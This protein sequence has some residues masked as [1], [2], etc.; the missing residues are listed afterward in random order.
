MFEYIFFL[1]IVFLLLCYVRK[2]KNSIF[3][4]LLLII[5]ICF[6]GF[7][8]GIG[9]DY[10]LYEEIYNHTDTIGADFF[11]T[12][13][14]YYS[15]SLFL[16]NIIPDGFWLLI[17][18]FSAITYV[19]I[20]FFCK[21]NSNIPGLSIFL[22]ICLG[23][24]PTSFNI[25]R[26]MASLAI[27]L[28][29]YTYLN[30]KKYFKTCIFFTI[31]ISLHEMSIIPILAILW[32]KVFRKNFNYKMLL[33]LGIL[34]L[35]Q[36]DFIYDILVENILSINVYSNSEKYIPGIGTYLQVVVYLFMYF[37]FNLNKEK[38]IKKDKLNEE[39][40]FLYNL[41]VIITLIGIKNILFIRLSNYLTI[42]SI[43]II[44][45]LYDLYD[46]KNRKLERAALY[47][48]Y[49]IYFFTYIY[50]FNEV[51]PYQSILFK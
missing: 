28:L 24:Y 8:Y 15:F 27:L 22:F 34:V 9:T 2:N 36:Y 46:L 17:F 5:L 12:G 21:E 4:I 42:Y 30:K 25:F 43:I 31:A 45:K 35:F 13:F 37:I 50:S 29:G 38:L 26:Q 11:R 44:P 14:G 10:K 6:S 19:S 48:C 16:H 41:G 3:D 20:Y 18:T 33:F 23:F 32:I 1:G 40:L 7:R 51:V 39:Y 47:M 49:I